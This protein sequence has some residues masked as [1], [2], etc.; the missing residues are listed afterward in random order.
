LPNFLQSGRGAP[1]MDN[2]DHVGDRMSVMLPPLSYDQKHPSTDQLPIHH[3]NHPHYSSPSTNPYYHHPEY[4][5]APN[6]QRQ[7]NYYGNYNTSNSPYYPPTTTT[8]PPPPPPPTSSASSSYPAY[9]HD[10]YNNNNNNN[11]YPRNEIYNP[12]NR[13]YKPNEIYNPG[14]GSYKPSPSRS[15]YVTSTASTRGGS[16]ADQRGYHQYHNYNYNYPPTTTED[17]VGGTGGRTKYYMHDS[18]RL[19][20][21]SVSANVNVGGINSLVNAVAVAAEGGN[22]HNRN[23]KEVHHQQQQSCNVNDIIDKNC[24]GNGN[25]VRGGSGGGSSIGEM[26]SDNSRHGSYDSQNNDH[27]GGKDG[28]QQ[29]QQQHQQQQQQQESGNGNNG[30]G[31]TSSTRSRAGARPYKCPLDGCRSIFSRRYNMVQHFRSHAQRLGFASEAIE[32]G[33]RALKASP[34]SMTPTAATNRELAAGT[35]RTLTV[36]VSS[37]ISASP[38]GLVV[39]GPTSMSGHPNHSYS[40]PGYYQH[41]NEYGHGHGHGGYQ[42]SGSYGGNGYAHSQSRGYPN[43]NELPP[44]PPPPPHHHPHHPYHEH[45]MPMNYP[46]HVPSQQPPQ[47]QSPY[48][49]VPPTTLSPPSQQQQHQQPLPPSTPQPQQQQ[50]HS[51]SSSSSLPLPSL[52]SLPPAPQSHPAFNESHNGYGHH[53]QQQYPYQ[54]P[55]QYHHSQPWQ[56][57]PPP[58]PMTGHQVVGGYYP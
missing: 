53:Q 33:A 47:Q 38:A 16:F 28:Q 10:G 46:T 23:D 6:Y 11:S 25:G 45:P 26:G 3:P 18:M 17:S 14:N 24:N 13:S 22:G 50:Y 36:P 37:V 57:G 2:G 29:Q 7:Q 19:Q 4:N 40:H 58:V 27:D 31:T 1:G 41:R 9:Y 32:R 55:Q 44:P 43:G 49:Q 52:S 48:Q 56:Q 8:A 20:Q 21:S 12:G 30:N 42:Q 54:Q 15:S 39:A 5:H 34:P 51:T 35:P